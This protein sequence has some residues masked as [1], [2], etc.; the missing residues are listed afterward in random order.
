MSEPV[1][2]ALRLDSEGIREYQRNRNPFL[3]MDEATEI[4]P[5]ASAK[6]YKQL[7]RSDWFFD[8]H[9]PGDPSM[10]GV[11]QVEALVQLCALTI[12]T[13]PGNKGKVAYLVAAGNIKLARKVIPGD[14][15]DLDTRLLTWNRGMGTCTGRATVD[16]QL[17]CRADFTLVLPDMLEQY[18]VAK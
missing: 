8:V 5:G 16:G 6:G 4:V 7:R 15:L 18:K 14:R 17:A 9:F 10:P 2:Q 11:L 12:L 1:Q 3:M 13:L